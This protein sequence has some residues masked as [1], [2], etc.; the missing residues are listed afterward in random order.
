MIEKPFADEKVEQ[1]Y[2][3]IWMAFELI[4]GSNEKAKEHMENYINKID[5]DKRI[6]VYKKEF[7]D[8]KK[9]EKPLKDVNVGYS[10]TSEIEFVIKTYDELVQLII[11]FGPSAI[12]ILEPHKIEMNIGEAQGI[13]N[14]ISQ[15]MH[16]F[17]AS[18]IGGILVAGKKE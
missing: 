15:M 4:A 7:S 12:E 2:M 17:A 1:G 16:R 6:Q 14:T 11:Q 8:V 5:E 18:G 10:I 13:L 9:I 3:R